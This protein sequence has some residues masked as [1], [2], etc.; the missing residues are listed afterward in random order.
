MMR[1]MNTEVNGQ[2]TEEK[3][4]PQRSAMKTKGYLEYKVSVVQ[5][6]TRHFRIFSMSS[7]SMSILEFACHEDSDLI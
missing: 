3:Q 6:T 1:K 5:N 7:W 2:R 4:E